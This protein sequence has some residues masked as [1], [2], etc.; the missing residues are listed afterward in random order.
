MLPLSP[1][2]T[3]K[4]VT[5]AVIALDGENA[6]AAMTQMHCNNPLAFYSSAAGGFFQAEIVPSWWCKAPSWV[7]LSFGFT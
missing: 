5:S 2:R 3:A 4:R 1:L 7:L 6:P